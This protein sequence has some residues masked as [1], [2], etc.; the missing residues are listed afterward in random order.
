MAARIRQLARDAVKS[1]VLALAT[2]PPVYGHLQRRAWRDRPL[3]ILCF[4]TLGGDADLMDAWT[5]LPIGEFRRLVAALREDYDI[6][7]LD[8]AL[9]GPAGT[10]PS[11]VLTF[12]DGDIGLYDHLL[13]LLRSEELPVLAYI[14]TGQI[15]EATPY[16]FDRIVNALQGPG[17]RRIDLAA[18]GLGLWTIGPEYGLSRCT[19]IGQLLNRLKTVAPDRR[20]ALVAQVLEQAAP[21][22]PPASPVGPMSLEQLREFAACPHVT[23]G[24]HSHC[25]NL[26][27]QIPLAEA[28]ASIALSR[29]LLRDWTRQDVAHFAY[30][31]S[32]HNAELRAEVARQGFATATVL[33]DSLAPRDQDPFALSRINIG[34]YNR[35]DRLRLRLVGY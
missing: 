27:D 3:S 7:S 12:D 17:E 31:N 4:H 35:L 5:V 21:I 8:Q 10:R 20:E 24:A 19:V 9:H 2:A 34:R 26:L 33:D 29:Q 15:A 13:P 30:P 23:I 1:T 14:A 18:D 16:W 28:A 6:V 25:H 22:T 32:N 11:L